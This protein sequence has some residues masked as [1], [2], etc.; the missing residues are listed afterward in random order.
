MKHIFSLFLFLVVNLFCFSLVYA[1]DNSQSFQ[2]EEQVDKK[3]VFSGGDLNAYITKY[4]QSNLTENEKKNKE[5][6]EVTFIITDEGS[7]V[8]VKFLKGNDKMIQAKIYNM[9]I[10]MP[11][12]IPAEKNGKKVNTSFILPIRFG[13][14]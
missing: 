3:A 1:Q 5:N 14:K 4:L 9:L 11:K 2:I 12:W 6:Y 13:S 10:T 7:V 8:G